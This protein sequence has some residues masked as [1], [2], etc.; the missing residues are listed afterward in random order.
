MYS[1]LRNGNAYEDGSIRRTKFK[2]NINI[3]RCPICE[4]R[5]EL[6]DSKDMVCMRGHSFNISR[7]GYVNLLLKPPKTKYDSDMFHSRSIICASGFFDPM[8]EYI[9]NLIVKKRVSD[10][11]KVL[12]AGCGEGSH[13]GEVTGYLRDI[14]TSRVQGV[15]IDISKDGILMASK[16]YFDIIWCVADLAKLP[17]I[18]QKFDVIINI[19]SPSNY[20]EF[21]RTL[22]DNGILIKVIPGSTYLKELRSALYVKGDKQTYSNDKIIEHYGNNFDVLDIKEML[23]RKRIDQ[24]ELIHLIRMTPLS[25]ATTERRIK[26]ALDMKIDEITVDYT[27]ITGKKRRDL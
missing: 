15:G 7:R 13:V 14:T 9:S 22:K 12:D 5:M 27:I 2:D 20:S 25:W 19:L 11:V 23:Y 21:H 18:D 3:F 1:N 26:E 4:E 8:L 24:E 6:C 17:F 10:N 16:A